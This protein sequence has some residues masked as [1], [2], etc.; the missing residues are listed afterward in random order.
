MDICREEREQK[1]KIVA[2]TARRKTCPLFWHVK[3][4]ECMPE[5]G[6]IWICSCHLDISVPP[7]EDIPGPYLFVIEQ[8]TGLLPWLMSCL[9]N[10]QMR[11]AFTH[12]Q[13]Q[14]NHLGRVHT[15]YSNVPKISCVN[16]IHQKAI[17]NLETFYHQC[18][19]N[20]YIQVRYVR[21]LLAC[22]HSPPAIV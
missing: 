6:R 15:M 8:G 3:C 11:T 16:S 4:P 10:P 19:L 5:R 12:A 20:L 18:L 14:I 2:M 17:L 22:Q 9:E 13:P 21:V 1:V 7:T